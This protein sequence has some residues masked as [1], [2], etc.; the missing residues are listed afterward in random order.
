M[1]DFSR[2]IDI[3]APQEVV[4]AHLVTAERMVLWMGQSA[5]LNATPGGTFAVDVNGYLFR[6]KYLEVE[7]PRRVVISWGLAGA[8][9][10]PP[11]SSLVEFTLSSTAT[12][13]R[14]NLVHSGLPDTRA[15]THAAGWAN[16]LARLQAAASGVDPGPDSWMP[17]TNGV[18]IGQGDGDGR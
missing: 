10:L 13:T 8:E 18:S 11:G 17:A 4:F 3:E 5:D 15:R 12:G 6:G 16:Y 7:P 1:P 2:S 14:L 9:D